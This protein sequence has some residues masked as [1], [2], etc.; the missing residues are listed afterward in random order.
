MWP[1]A[2]LFLPK[3]YRSMSGRVLDG[4]VF[5]Q[6]KCVPLVAITDSIFLQIGGRCLNCFSALLTSAFYRTYSFLFQLLI[7]QRQYLIG[8][9]TPPQW[10]LGCSCIF[11]K[12]CWSAAGWGGECTGES[13]GDGY[14]CICK[15]S[16]WWYVSNPY[17]SPPIFNIAD[18]KRKSN[19]QNS[20][21]WCLQTRKESCVGFHGLSVAVYMAT[22]G[23]TE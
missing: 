7:G 15:I 21:S 13:V 20:L 6:P 2:D 10:L 4:L 8:T 22:S 18:K 3:M 14:H 17:C 5:Q 23:Y 19:T 12:W 11:R 1:F 16:C 9:F